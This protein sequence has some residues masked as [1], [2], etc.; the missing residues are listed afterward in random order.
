MLSD[1][2]GE[3][4][5]DLNW[6]EEVSGNGTNGIVRRERHFKREVMQR[7]LHKPPLWNLKE[8]RYPPG[9]HAPRRPRT[10]STQFSFETGASKRAKGVL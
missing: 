9:S 8:I 10:V 5:T 1:R 3:L 2:E 4:T 6:K 7:Q